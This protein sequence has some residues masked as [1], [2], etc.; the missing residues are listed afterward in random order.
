MCITP[1][2]LFVKNYQFSI[3]RRSANVQYVYQS[4]PVS[5]PG[6]NLLCHDSGRARKHRLLSS[7]SKD[8]ETSRIT[9][10]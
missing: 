3:P 10:Q 4:L 7:W 6:M 1:S 8:S 2:V 5:K 9:K